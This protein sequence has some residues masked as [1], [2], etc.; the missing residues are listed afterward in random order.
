ME[1]T[2]A[3][4][5]STLFSLTSAAAV[6]CGHHESGVE[7]GARRQKWR[8]SFVERGIHQPLQ[9]PL[10]DARQRAE[11]DGQEIEREGQR[12]AV[13]VAA[14]EDDARERCAPTARF[15]AP[16]FFSS[17]KTSGLSTAEFISI[18]KTSRQWARV[19][20]TAPCTCGMQRSE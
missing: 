6:T 17:G 3:G 7:A 2:D 4:C 9:A 15:G 12:L 20:R 5:D 14:G 18:S 13:E 10:G 11:R 16:T 1:S 8:Q 19:S